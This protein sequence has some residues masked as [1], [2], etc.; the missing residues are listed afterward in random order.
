MDSQ[1]EQYRQARRH[2][3]KLRG[4]YIHLGI[5]V[6]V[7]AA[8]L[9]LNMVAGRPFWAIWLIAGWGIGLAAHGMSVVGW[10]LFGR[11]WEERKIRERLDREKK[12]SDR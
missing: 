1:D 7:N 11:E 10:S 6:I 4:F 9:A 8:L 5:Y 2:V 3:R 12:G